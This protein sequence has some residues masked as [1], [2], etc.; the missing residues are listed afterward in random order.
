MPLRAY[1]RDPR[2][3]A[4]LACLLLGWGGV[5]YG[6][7][8]YDDYP[9]ILN[10]SATALGSA[11]WERLTSGIRPLTR[12]TYAWD[13][14]LWPGTPGAW[15][16]TNWLL[17]VVTTL[18]VWR[19]GRNY[20]LN[21]AAR[22]M[23]ALVFALQ[24]AH[25]WAIAYVS[26]RSG[27]LMTALLVLALVAHDHG[28]ADASKRA[29]GTVAAILLFG[30]AVA[31]K[32]VAVVFPPLLLLWE[33]SRTGG[34]RS[35]RLAVRSVLPFALAA[36]AL[37]AYALTLP[38]YRELL[39]YSLNLRAPVNALRQNLT[40]LPLTASL[41][42]RPWALSVE[43]GPPPT[44]PIASVAG[45]ALMVVWVTVAAH[46]CRKR[47]LATLGMLWPLIALL[48]T[49]S[50][51]AK[52]DAINESSLYLAWVGPSL[53][54]GAALGHWLTQPR[55]ARAMRYYFATIGI[56]ILLGCCQWR[57]MMW[58]DPVR[59]W[60]EAVAAAPQSSRA[61]NNLGMAHLAKNN[62]KSAKRSFR[63]ALQLDPD[64]WQAQFNLDMTGLF[65]IRSKKGEEN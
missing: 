13:F 37:L 19:L 18:G 63:Q 50:I 62:V 58:G 7:F 51:I 2:A 30:A 10:D 5:V 12:L 54:L 34:A 65:M 14:A 23:A 61:W 31:A 36:F 3:W 8:Q 28:A 48:P 29:R 27:A 55:P 32:E 24:P 64:N 59:L 41:L 35:V 25:G 4:T 49:H 38:R 15:L 44:G 47:P 52:A 46:L 16:V 6:S 33:L 1:L 21:P 60:Q 22:W 26:G 20:G 45:A 42:L 9:N 57:T 43:H 40:A 39:D 17:H 11:L 53:A 56:S